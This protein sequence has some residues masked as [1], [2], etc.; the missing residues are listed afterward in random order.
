VVDEVV[1]E[2]LE[3]EGGSP[4]TT[5]VAMEHR[6]FR[7]RRPEEEGCRGYGASSIGA[8]S[9]RPQETR[10]EMPSMLGKIEVMY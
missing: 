10:K 8:R 5:E 1:K 2:V 9:F 6:G 4:P 7:H 3:R